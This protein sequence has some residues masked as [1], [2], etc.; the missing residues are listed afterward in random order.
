MQSAFLA[1]KKTY[2]RGL[3]AKD[4]E[5]YLI[6]WY[7]DR[8]VTRYLFRGTYPG[9]PER[10][11]L[12]Y[13]A[14]CA[15]TRDIELLL[16][17]RK[18]DIALGVAGL[19]GINPVAHSAELR[20]LIG[21]K[22]YWGKGY[23]TEATQLLLAYAFEV[24]NLHKVYLGVNAAQGNAVRVYEKAG[25]VREGRLRD[26]IYRNGRYYDAIRMSILKSEYQ[27]EKYKWDIADE[28]NRQFPA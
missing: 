7:N 6:D 4:L 3:Q 26:E 10:L 16:L 12:E 25:F 8:E 11:Q 18:D 13:Q 20:M 5:D 17:E 9:T 15:S 2:L 28:I 19:Y 27:Q 24:L 21:E 1:G 14:N 22:S 23:A